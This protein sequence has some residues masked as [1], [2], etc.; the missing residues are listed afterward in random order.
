MRGGMGGEWFVGMVRREGGILRW[1]GGG[2]G[3]GVGTS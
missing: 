2:D 1:K 3:R